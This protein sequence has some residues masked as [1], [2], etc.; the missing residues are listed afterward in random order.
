MRKEIRNIY[1]GPDKAYA[2]LDFSGVGYVT[3]Q[4][5]V[6]SIICKR[7]PFTEEEIRDFFFQTNA[8]AGNAQVLAGGMNFDSFKKTFF[9]HLYQIQD[10]QQHMATIDDDQACA[11]LDEE[12]QRRV[13]LR[14][15]LSNKTQ[16]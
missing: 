9:P 4:N 11:G 5:F 14:N 16:H 8:F 2:A 1:R 13:R 15:L 10:D 3:L 12:E 6:D 7:L